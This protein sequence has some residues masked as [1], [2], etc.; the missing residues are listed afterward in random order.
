[1]GTAQ[2]RAD[3]P[4]PSRPCRHDTGRVPNRRSGQHADH[5]HAQGPSSGWHCLPRLLRRRLGHLGTP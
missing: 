1:M 3:R 2:E 4:L 5:Q